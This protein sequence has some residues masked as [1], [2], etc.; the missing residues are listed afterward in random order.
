MKPAITRMTVFRLNM[1]CL[2]LLMFVLSL[3]SDLCAGDGNKTNYGDAAILSS[4][5]AARP[6]AYEAV[7]PCYDGMQCVA[8]DMCSTPGEYPVAFV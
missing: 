2:C 3:A 8:V 6:T 5:H 4:I 1:E 7:D